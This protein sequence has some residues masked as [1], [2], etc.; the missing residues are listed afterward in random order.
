MITFT[1]AQLDAWL[2]LFMFPLARILGLLA[3]APVFNNAAL[4]TQVR[5][6]TGL[7]IALALAPALPPLPP[8]PAGSWTAL[9]ILAEQV[10]IGTLLGFTL[11]IAFAAV[12]IA[13]ELIGLQM[14]LG[15]ATFFDPDS[16]GQT[17][18]IA[19]WLQSRAAVKMARG[20]SA[21]GFIGIVRISSSSDR[22]A[23]P[24]VMTVWTRLGWCCHRGESA[25]AA[26]GPSTS[27]A[28]AT[29]ANRNIH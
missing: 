7:A 11:R 28:S 10:L 3:S 24:T 20:R 8:I 2:A 21:G 26:A 16:G 29:A 25:K 6:V 15:F 18:V 9:V 4:P 14:G 17:P 13:G 27:V 5:L 22:V 23:S 1:S 19:M 12:D